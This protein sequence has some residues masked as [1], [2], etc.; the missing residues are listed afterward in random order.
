MI[1]EFDY[2]KSKR[3]KAKKILQTL[4]A[5]ED[6]LYLYPDDFDLDVSLSFNDQELENNEISF[7]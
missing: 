1:M 7:D 4:N 2:K 6:Q 5:F 3:E